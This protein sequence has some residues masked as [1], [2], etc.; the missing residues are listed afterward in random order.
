VFITRCLSVA[1]KK[2]TLFERERDLERVT[3]LHCRGLS[4]RAIAEQLQVSQ[5]QIAYDMKRLQKRW[6]ES[7]QE[8]LERYK[9]EQLA[10][11]DHVERIAWEAW[12]R[13]CQDAETTSVK[14]V[15]GRTD[16]QGQPLPDLRTSAQVT[17]GQAGDPR[18]LERVGWCIERRCKILGLDAP[19]KLA[20]T[21][22]SGN[23]EYGELSDEEAADGLE[24][25]VT[26]LESRHLPPFNTQDG[27]SPRPTGEHANGHTPPHTPNSS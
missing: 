16:K 5:P 25:L 12:E 4:Q 1:A 27:D 22:P 6:Q 17:K 19:T 9:A 20:P 3:D 8:K 15:E 21:D 11:I 26:I 18:F 24:K 7:A 14:L 23:H 13:S 2:R 10:R